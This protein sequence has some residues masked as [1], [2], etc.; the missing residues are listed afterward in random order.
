MPRSRSRDLSDRFVGRRDYYRRG[1]SV[2]W[3]KYALSVVAFVAAL[4]W[5][6]FEWL[7]PTR[8]AVAHTHGDLA[9]PHAAWSDNCA[10]CHLESSSSLSLASAIF[11]TGDRWRELTCQKCHAGPVHHAH[12]TPGAAQTDCA[13][14]HHD[15]QGREHSLTRLT[16]SHCTSCHADLPRHHTQGKSIYTTSITDFATHPEFSKVLTF[17][18]S[19]DR[20]L[21]FSHAV[22]MNPGQSY[23]KDGRDPPPA[24]AV[25]LECSS[26]H[27]LD[28]GIN[29]D[30]YR[31]AVASLA[32][33]PTRSILPPRAEGAYFL[34]INY[35]LHCKSCHPTAVSPGV[36]GVEVLK[37]IDLPHRLQPE[38][39][40]PILREKVAGALL[41]D[42]PSL[43]RP[44]SQRLD[45]PSKEP[46][47]MAF[48]NRVESLTEAGMKELLQDP[49][50]ENSPLSIATGCVKCHDLNTPG[51][52]RKVE[53]L[54]DHTIWFEHAK[55]NHGSHRGVACAECHTGMAPTFRA[56]GQVEWVAKEPLR[57]LG[58]ESCRQCHGPARSTPHGQEG[59]IRHGCTD[60]H[61]FHNGDFPLQ[62]L[63]GANRNPRTSRTVQE[64]LRGSP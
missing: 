3:W 42:H 43:H 44:P 16:D 51:P 47:V 55:F 58:V 7:S 28:S 33:Q 52:M 2:R 5:A 27:Q 22:H 50:A 8:A 63:G 30:A 6:A 54:P 60:C 39:L 49:P 25:K 19:T 31:Q 62:A 46:E 45:R 64:F 12:A 61:R 59:G 37:S 34:P 48:R 10:A 36:V 17:D 21:K 35:D 38:S 56:N 4:G 14:C 24:D 40:K 18:A 11:E 1:D 29:G 32:G 9:S 41:R 13:S 53:A 15:H 20:K 57:I 23:V 26:C